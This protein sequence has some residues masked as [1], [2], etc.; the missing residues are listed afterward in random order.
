M[1]QTDKTKDFIR[2]ALL[3]HGDKYDYSKVEYIKAIEKVIII[4]KQHGDFLQQPNNHLTGNECIKCSIL[5]RNDNSRYTTEIFINKAK[6]IHGEVYDYS[7]VNYIDSKTKIIIICK[8]H[9]EYS[10]APNKHLQKQGCPKCMCYEKSNNK[11]FIEKAT[12]IHGDKYDYSKVEYIN[13][14]TKV[15]IICK[16][17][18][19]FLQVPN[20]H[21]QGYACKECGYEITADKLSTN[22]E[23]FIIKARE[24][25]GY[26]YDYSKVEYINCNT[27][28]IIICDKHGEFQQTPSTHL[29]STYGCPSCAVIQKSENRINNCKDIFIEKAIKIHGDKY[30][31]SKS[32]YTGCE[33]KLTIICKTHGEFL[34]QPNNHL[35]GK[36]CYKCGLYEF[37]NSRISNSSEF[38]EKSIKIHGDKYDYSKVNYTNSKTKI[39][40]TCKKHGD[41]EQTPSGHGGGKGCNLC[42]NERIKEKKSS[43]I[44][45]FIIKATKIHGDE[46]DYSK[47]KYTKSN[48]LVTII[49]KTHGDFKIRPNNHI[50][51]KQGCPKCQINKQHSKQQIHWLN[52]IQ[53]RD[54]IIIRHA[55][56][57]GEFK[58]PNTKYIADGYCEENNTIYEFH[59]DYWHGNPIKFIQNDM[60]KTIKTTF[61]EL[62]KKTLDKEK[63]I[64]ELGYNLVVIWENDWKKI[65][66]CVKIIQNR[67]RKSKY[68]AVPYF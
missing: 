20:S 25:H 48:E 47:V 46:Y 19:E 16:M 41:F 66:K 24:I 57:N 60:N 59:G 13:S 37:I 44:D 42:G 50:G 10:Q 30:D 45:E 51:S 65:N 1:E 3:V 17:H 32:I 58:I 34:Q 7:K 26:K 43:N 12:K 68:S 33:N 21:L 31:Y 15:I 55:E 8:Q 64:R 49:C 28:I 35:Y 40:I 39:I 22:I 62:Y 53:T 61:G 11:E 6:E 5:R 29:N 52:F 9:G 38:I 18:G 14:Q 2:K 67:F 23:D 56:N 36:G 4:C 54:N 27:N 63:Q